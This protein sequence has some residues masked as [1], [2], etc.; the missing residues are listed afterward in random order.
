MRASPTSLVQPLT[1]GY[2]SRDQDKPEAIQVQAKRKPVSFSSDNV[3]GITG[4]SP[5]SRPTEEV[6]YVIPILPKTLRTPSDVPTEDAAVLQIWE[7]TVLDVDFDQEVLRALLH[8]KGRGDIDD[9]VGDI[10]FVWV[11][12]QDRDLLKPG[13]VFYLTLYKSRKPG[14]TIVNA[15]ELRFRRLPAWTSRQISKANELADAM[16]P[17][18]QS[19]PIAE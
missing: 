7:G 18:I 1:R 2:G 12:E 5:Q 13:A 4:T 17:K 16:L 8:P 9:H 6:D 10:H 3:S 14:G 19:R 11:M 15:Q